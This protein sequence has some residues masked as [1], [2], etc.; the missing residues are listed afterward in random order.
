[1]FQT[2]YTMDRYNEETIEQGGIK[3]KTQVKQRVREEERSEH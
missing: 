3:V 1:M 2:E